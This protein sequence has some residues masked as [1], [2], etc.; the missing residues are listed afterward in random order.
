[1]DVCTLKLTNQ[2]IKHIAMQQ[3]AI[4]ANSEVFV[5]AMNK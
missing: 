2:M 1:M 3:S 4:D 5:N